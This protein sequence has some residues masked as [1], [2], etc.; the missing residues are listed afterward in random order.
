MR[1]G[2]REHGYL[3]R[4]RPCRAARCLQLVG[5]WLPCPHAPPGSA[6][7]CKEYASPNSIIMAKLTKLL[8]VSSVAAQE[9]G[10]GLLAREQQ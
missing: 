10:G 8:H 3:G 5:I 2:T 6:C 1:G 4:T 7:I 9:G